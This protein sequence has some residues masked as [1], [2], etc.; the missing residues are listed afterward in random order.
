[1]ATLKERVNFIKI[2][3]QCD[4]NS[5]TLDRHVT[6]FE[7]PAACFDNDE[8]MRQKLRSLY[9]WHAPVMVLGYTD[10]GVYKDLYVYFDY[11]S[12]GMVNKVATKIFKMYGLEGLQH[13]M[14]WDT[15]QGDCIMMRADPPRWS[16]TPLGAPLEKYDKTLS[17]REIIKTITYFKTR[18]A[19]NVARSRDAARFISTLSPEEVKSRGRGTMVYG[20]ATSFIPVGQKKAQHLATDRCNL[21]GKSGTLTRDLKRCPCK[22]AFYCNKKCQQSDWKK[23]KLV[24]SKRKPQTDLTKK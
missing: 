3:A 14:N 2:S 12:N 1:M 22:N 24:C 23:H 15:I 10:K 8:L 6:K 20:T 17:R 16:D 13:E 11:A 9:G 18:N 4:F 7:L 5:E 19:Y 21:C